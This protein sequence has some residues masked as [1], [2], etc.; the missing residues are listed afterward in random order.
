[1]RLSVVSLALFAASASAHFTLD[2]PQTR[3]FDEDKEPQFCGGFPV[4]SRSLFPLSGGMVDINSHHQSSEFVTLISFDANPTSFSEFNTTSSGQNI[5]FLI[6]FVKLQG[7]G[8]VCMPVNIAAL[9]IQ[10]VTNGTNATIQV[11]FNGG[12]GNLY[13]CADVTLTTD[14]ITPPACQNVSTILGVSQTDPGVSPSNA[15]SSAGPKPTNAAQ[16]LSALPITSLA[17]LAA[18]AAGLSITL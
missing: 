10:G 12:D 5:P 13:Q 6:P 8:T 3:G 1:M 4:G 14:S 9:N 17:A 16:A 2:Y 11:Q 7:T 15:S 18:A